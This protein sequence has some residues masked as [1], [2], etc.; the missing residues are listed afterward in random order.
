VRQVEVVHGGERGHVVGAAGRVHAAG[1]AE[2]GRAPRL[3]HREE[4]ADP[5]AERVRHDGG[6]LAEPLGGRPARPAARVLEGLRQVPVVERDRGF[7]ARGEQR[8]DQVGV[9]GEARRVDRPQ[10]LG[11]DV[12]R[13][14]RPRHRESV[15][16]EPEVGHE[17][18]VL[19]EAVV[20]V[21]GHVAGVVARDPARRVREGV[22]DRGGA[23]VGGTAPSIW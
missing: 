4:A 17:G 6:E 1:V 22:P 9:E 14:P 13:D 5:V 19:A 18:D 12:R 10:L 21:H 8:V 11:G 16:G 2:V 15:G 3:V 23:A 20:V 7:D